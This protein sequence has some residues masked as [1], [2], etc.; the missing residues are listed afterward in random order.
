MGQGWEERA[1]EVGG[2]SEKRAC[3]AATPHGSK[4]RSAGVGWE[5]GDG[6]N[7]TE[8]VMERIRSTCTTR[9]VERACQGLELALPLECIPNPDL[10]MA[11][12]TIGT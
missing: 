5:D 3:F 8:S 4:S 11:V 10:S 7:E 2:H 1:L 12:T 6:E 9:T